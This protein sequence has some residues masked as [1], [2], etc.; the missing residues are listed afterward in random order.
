[1]G[2]R[3]HAKL[4]CHSLY[5]VLLFWL[6]IS[7]HGR[8][9]RARSPPATKD[10][11]VRQSQRHWHAHKHRLQ[12]MKLDG[13]HLL[14]ILGPIM[15]HQYTLPMTQVQKS[16]VYT[17][18]NYRLRRVVH[19]MVM[20]KKPIKVGAIGGSITHGAKASVIGKT[21]WFSLVGTYLQSAFP[22][23]N[24]TTRNG[25]LPATPSALMNMCL[26][27]YVDKD[28]DLMFV[29]YVANDGANR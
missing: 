24:I 23:A 10:E 1:M 27:Q 6:A 9:D 4:V 3:G 8:P 19:D 13:R 26:E 21:D 20:G 5:G 22:K 29:E 25:A 16:L 11:A 17:G 14:D 28:V 12:S 7:A 2:G 18:S 15:D